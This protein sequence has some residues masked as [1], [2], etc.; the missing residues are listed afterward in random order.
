[1]QS[2]WLP[3]TPVSSQEHLGVL[4]EDPVDLQFNHSGYLFLASQE[5]AHIMEENYST[6]RC[7]LSSSSSRTVWYG[8]D[9]NQLLQTENVSIQKFEMEIFRLQGWGS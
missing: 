1:M 5:V 3:H 8:S 9:R 6:Q 7:R 4:N 2:D